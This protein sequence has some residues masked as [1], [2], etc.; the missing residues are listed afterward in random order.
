ML[1]FTSIPL[2]TLSVTIQKSWK[3]S[4][5]LFDLGM[6]SALIA[7]WSFTFIDAILHLPF[8]FLR[9]TVSTDAF[10]PSTSTLALLRQK[11]RLEL[12]QLPTAAESMREG[13]G[14]AFLPSGSASSVTSSGMPGKSNSTLNW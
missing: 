13:F 10:R 2:R 7:G 12:R 5:H 1:T 11:S 3:T 8:S 14:P 6:S 9:I 4:R